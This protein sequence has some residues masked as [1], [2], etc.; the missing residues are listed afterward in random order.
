MADAGIR[1]NDF[2]ILKRSLSPTKKGVTFD[3]ALE[4]QLGIQI[5]RVRFAETVDLH[6]MIDHQLGGEKR[7][8]LPGIAAHA[9]DGFAHGGQ[10][11]DGGHAGKILKQHARGHEGNLFFRGSR[12]PVRQGANVIGPHKSPVFAAHKI[13]EKDP[14]RERQLRQM[15]RDLFLKQFE[16]VDVERL[17]AH[18]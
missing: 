15:A 3:V 13:F 1:R 16:P 8:D 18:V 14:Q 10:I 17:R 9:F 5:E 4:F 6:G 7:I 12:R 11:D 2:E